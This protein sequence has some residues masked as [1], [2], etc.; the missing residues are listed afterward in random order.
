MAK[1]IQNM[2]TSHKNQEISY[3]HDLTVARRKYEVTK[4]HVNRL[5]SKHEMKLIEM[6]RKMICLKNMKFP[7][8]GRSLWY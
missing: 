4:S 3:A 6:I 1:A 2:D 5:N 8:N 7:P